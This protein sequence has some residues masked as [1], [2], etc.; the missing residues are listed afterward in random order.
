MGILLC[1]NHSAP[2][3]TPLPSASKEADSTS[4]LFLDTRWVGDS[5]GIQNTTCIGSP[6]SGTPNVQFLCKG[7]RSE[8]LFVL[9]KLWRRCFPVPVAPSAPPSLVLSATSHA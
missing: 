2:F 4:P 5:L 7:N 6:C 8:C 1:S 9:V 3:H